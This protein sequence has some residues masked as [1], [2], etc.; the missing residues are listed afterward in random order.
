MSPDIHQAITCSEFIKL[1]T[2]TLED[3]ENPIE[4]LEVICSKSQGRVN[5][6]VILPSGKQ[7]NFE[8]PNG[9]IGVGVGVGGGLN[10]AAMQWQHI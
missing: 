6:D 7:A 5:L 8:A 9:A 3:G 1:E 4:K 2:S 10:G